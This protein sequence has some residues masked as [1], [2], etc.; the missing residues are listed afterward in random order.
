[1]R[2][3]CQKILKELMNDLE[4]PLQKVLTSS[5]AELQGIDFRSEACSNTAF[6]LSISTN[7]ERNIKP[8]RIIFCR[9]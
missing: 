3:D 2:F 4:K 9:G 5:N 1:M 7:N 8:K 6:V